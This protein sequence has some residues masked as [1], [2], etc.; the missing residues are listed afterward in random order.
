MEFGTKEGWIDKRMDV[1][2]REKRS[3]INCFISFILWKPY[4]F[5]VFRPKRVLLISA[6][7][8]A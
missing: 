7:V 1:N 5:D 8:L 6:T 4:K 2:R 3:L